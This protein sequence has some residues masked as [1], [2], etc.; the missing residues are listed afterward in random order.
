MKYGMTIA[1][2]AVESV[3]LLAEGHGDAVVM[4]SDSRSGVVDPAS[5][6]LY[7]DTVKGTETAGSI[8]DMEKGT[9][10]VR[11]GVG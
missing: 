2:L 6:A 10:I 9:K 3:K 7:L 5:G 11:M 1:E 4:I 8:I